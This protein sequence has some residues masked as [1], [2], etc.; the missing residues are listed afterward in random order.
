MN[1]SRGLRITYD[2]VDSRFLVQCTQELAIGV[3]D[4]RVAIRCDRE[5]SRFLSNQN[6]LQGGRVGPPLLEGVVRW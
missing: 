1:T 2:E 3:P 5:G 4:R 6:H